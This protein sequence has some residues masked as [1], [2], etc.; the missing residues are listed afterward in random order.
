MDSQNSS[1]PKFQ[2]CNDTESNQSDDQYPAKVDIGVLKD[3][4]GGYRLVDITCI[5]C[6]Q[7][8]TMQKQ[9][10]NHSVCNNCVIVPKN[11]G[12]YKH[13]FRTY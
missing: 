3:I 10:S 9:Y 2:E 11:S 13:Y 12:K 7:T 4:L 6:N 8:R 5:H 1:P